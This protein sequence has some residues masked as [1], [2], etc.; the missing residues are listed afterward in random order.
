MGTCI[1]GNARCPS[2]ARHSAGRLGQASLQFGGRFAEAGNWCALRKGLFG[3]LGAAG[4]SMQSAVSAT[5]ACKA[6]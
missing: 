3:D 4:F 2:P 5:T 1:P 6:V